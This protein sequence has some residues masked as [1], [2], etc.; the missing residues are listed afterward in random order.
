MCRQGD[1]MN[2]LDLYREMG[3][4]ARFVGT[5]PSRGAEWQGKCPCD[6]NSHDRFH[7]F[8]DQ[9][10]GKGSWWCRKCDKTGGVF[11]FLTT[12]AGLSPA[13]AALRLGLQLRGQGA[14]ELFHTGVGVTEAMQYVPVERRHNGVA[15]EAKW[16]SHAC[17][18]THIAHDHLLNSGTPLARAA[19]TWL[20][21]RGVS[22]AAMETFLLGF[23]ET[24]K[25]QPSYRQREAWGIVMEEGDRPV[26]ALPHGIVIPRLQ[27][28][29]VVALRIRRSPI[30]VSAETPKYHMVKGSCNASM[31]LPSTDRRCDTVVV[32]ES[33]LDALA[34]WSLARD[35]VH[36]VALGSLT[37]RPDAVVW[38][39]ITQARVV[40]LCLDHDVDGA[41]V[42]SSGVVQAHQWWVRA[43]PDASRNLKIVFAPV[44]KDV[45]E[46]I[47]SGADIRAWLCACDP[48]LP[49]RAG[50]QRVSAAA[51]SVESP[52]L[53]D[54]TRLARV[55]GSVVLADRIIS[56]MRRVPAKLQVARGGVGIKWVSDRNFEAF[57]QLSELLFEAEG[58]VL[59]SRIAQAYPTGLYR[60]EDFLR[61]RN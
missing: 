13:D 52:S 38:P 9:A 51:A 40:L 8:P 49:L 36:V 28:D 59:W 47:T 11:S 34:L 44:G 55:V 19:M 12:F 17:K 1:G 6:S 41:G 58:G 56:L 20:L 5:S 45:G 48:V 25:R 2:C 27:N 26:F 46:S 57:A 32:V 21:Q 15:D 53:A 39:L 42:L 54:G 29:Q 61:I 22:M 33:E 18:F 31:L 10:N 14:G 7:I 24:P 3:H 50:A 43:L 60:P 16:R 30:D 35:L 4:E 37:A 23:H